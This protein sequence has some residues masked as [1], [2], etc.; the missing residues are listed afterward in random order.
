MRPFQ[1]GVGHFTIPEPLLFGIPLQ[2]AGYFH[3]NMADQTDGAGPVPYLDRGDR[4]LSGL[5]AIEPV[6]VMIIAYIEMDLILLDLRGKALRIA[7]I[8]CFGVVALRYRI[9]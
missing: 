9:A 1:H 6:A 3:R 8:Q 7:C 5:D 2:S 4:F